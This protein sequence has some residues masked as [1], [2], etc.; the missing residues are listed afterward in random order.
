[1][2]FFLHYVYRFSRHYSNEYDP[3]KIFLL[4]CRAYRAEDIKMG[5]TPRAG[6]GR[7]ASS[8]RCGRLQEVGRGLNFIDTNARFSYTLLARGIEA[9]GFCCKVS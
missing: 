6:P 2:P 9:Y 7:M 1:M 3:V 4:K 8:L 5:S